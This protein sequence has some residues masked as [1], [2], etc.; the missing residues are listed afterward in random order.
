M[1]QVQGGVGK[2]TAM[3][4]RAEASKVSVAIVQGSKAAPRLL[5][6]VVLEAANEDVSVGE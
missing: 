4:L 6:R 5:L 1:S 3:G 2:M